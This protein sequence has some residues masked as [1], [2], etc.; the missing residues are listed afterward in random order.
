ME[1]PWYVWSCWETPPIDLD[2]IVAAAADTYPGYAGRAA[3]RAE[4]LC[5]TDNPRRRTGT[6]LALD[7][8]CPEGHPLAGYA[9]EQ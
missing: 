7:A 2:R 3:L 1:A 5:G 4:V 6:H 8:P 9:D